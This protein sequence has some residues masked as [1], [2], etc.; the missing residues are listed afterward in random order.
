MELGILLLLKLVK[1]LHLKCMDQIGQ[2]NVIGSGIMIV[3]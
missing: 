1:L 3:V 2:E